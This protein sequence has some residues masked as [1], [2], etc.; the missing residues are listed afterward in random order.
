MQNKLTTHLNE[1]ISYR[2]ALIAVTAFLCLIGLL[3]IYASSSIPAYQ[4]TGDALMH[5]KKQFLVGGFGFLLIFATGHLP[6]HWI[7][8]LTLPSVLLSFILLALVHVPALEGHAKRGFP[9]AY[10]SRCQYPAG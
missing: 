6:F 1:L 7:E 9:V 4:N 5:V 10:G 2:T 8:K 3:A